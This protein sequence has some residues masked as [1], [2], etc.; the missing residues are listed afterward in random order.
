MDFSLAAPTRRRTNTPPAGG[1]RSPSRWPRS[2]PSSMSPCRNSPAAAWA[3]RRHPRQ[4]PVDCR[5]AQA[6]MSN[7]RILPASTTSARSSAPPAPAWPRRQKLTRCVTSPARWRRSAIASSIMSKKIAEG[8]GRAGARRQS[9]LRR[10]HEGPSPRHAVRR[11]M[12]DLGTDAGVKT[13]ALLTNMLGS[14]QPHRRRN[15]LG[16]ASPSG[17]SPV[18]G[19]PTSSAHRPSG[20]GMLGPRWS[21]RPGRRRR[22]AGTVARWTRGAA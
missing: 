8:T 18:V 10:L 19:Q 15:A 20:R 16:S 11:T 1:R 2:S 5:L 14:T 12:V 21:R 4:A 22:S 6:S 7:E 13:V 17:C 9:R 3:H